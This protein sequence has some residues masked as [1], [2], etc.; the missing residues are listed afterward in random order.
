[1]MDFDAAKSA[2]ARIEASGALDRTR[3]RILEVLGVPKRPSAPPAKRGS[4]ASPIPIEATAT[5]LDSIL[6]AIP[7]LPAASGLESEPDDMP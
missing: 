1:M 4:M 3:G 2:S 5:P 6:D 7:A